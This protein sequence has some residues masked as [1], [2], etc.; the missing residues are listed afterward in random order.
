MCKVTFIITFAVF[1]TLLDRAM[2]IKCY[3]CT[4]GPSN[5]HANRTQQLCL[6]FT[7]N[8]D[9]IVDCPYSTMCMKKIFQYELLDGKK[10][11]TVSRDCAHQKYT[12]QV[13]KQGSWQ[14]ENTVEEPYEEGCQ[15]SESQKEIG[16]V[17]SSTIYCHCRGSLCNSAPKDSPSYHTDAMA[18]IFVFNAM[19]YLRSID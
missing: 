17:G 8:D 12:E 16:I 7:E 13:F 15:G 5:R 4:V 18:V 1:M 3:R 9:Y 19:K 11:E 2:T 14:N 10:I 6:K